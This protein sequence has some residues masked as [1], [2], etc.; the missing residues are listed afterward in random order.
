[1]AE[2]LLHL[3]DGLLPVGFLGV[4]LVD[5]HDERQLVLIGVTSEDVCAHLDAL[6]CVDDKNTVLADLEG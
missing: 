4:K 5:S 2:S 6:L 3:G 1:M